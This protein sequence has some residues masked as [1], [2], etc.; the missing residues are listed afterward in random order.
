[1]SDPVFALTFLAA[2]G[3]AL[4]A[5]VFFAFSSFVMQGLGR[6]PAG[7][8]V[9]SM[10]AI[11]ATALTPVFMSALFGTAALCLL[12]A[13][14]SVPDLD[15]ASGRYRLAGAAL[16]LVGTIVVTLVLNV[17]LNHALDRADP[18]GPEAGDAWRGY[19]SRW[20]AW[21]HVRTAFSLAATAAL[22]GALAS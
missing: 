6:L 15:A 1:M 21:N 16:Y 14:S 2:L 3:C 5:G 4:A 8:S 22:I 19:V 9:A 18:D 10:Q 11:N 20:Q 12:V 13:V 17:P 7:G